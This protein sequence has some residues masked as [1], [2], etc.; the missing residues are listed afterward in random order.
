MEANA[1]THEEA[2]LLMSNMEER[3]EFAGVQPKTRTT[4]EDGTIQLS[5]GRQG[6]RHQGRQDAQHVLVRHFKKPGEE[7]ARIGRH[8][9][10]LEQRAVL[11]RKVQQLAH[12]LTFSL[13]RGLGLARA[14]GFGDRLVAVRELELRAHVPQAALLMALAAMSRSA[15]CGLL[16]SSTLTA[17]WRCRSR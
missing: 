14:D 4:M 2:M 3:P 13:E 7:R 1:R 9:P 10:R 15:I 8:R 12:G 11:V 16:S 6:F 5:A 17:F